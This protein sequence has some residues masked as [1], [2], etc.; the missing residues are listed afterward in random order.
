ML[1]LIMRKLKYTS[2]EETNRIIHVL[3]CEIDELERRLDKE[4]EAHRRTRTVYRR[5][6]DAMRMK[7]IGVD[8]MISKIAKEYDGVNRK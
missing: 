4:R 8:V 3:R 6:I 2:D 1:D 5:V 7:F